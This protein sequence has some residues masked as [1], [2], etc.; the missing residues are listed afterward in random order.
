MR[1][2]AE[3]LTR[4]FRRVVTGRNTEGDDTFDVVLRTNRRKSYTLRLVAGP[5]YP[6]AMPRA[7]LIAPRALRD[8]DGALLS[9]L[10]PSVSMHLL[11]SEG[12]NPQVC[13]DHPGRWNASQTL[14][15]VALKV[16]VWLEMY[17][18]HLDTGLPLDAWLS[19][20]ENP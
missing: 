8:A 2:E 14:Y 19:H 4:Y 20:V 17:E 18:L 15:K 3:L 13:H 6:D 16:R 11:T 12:A 7:F 5:R 1:L 10:G 9:S